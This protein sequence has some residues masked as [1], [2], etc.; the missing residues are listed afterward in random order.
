MQLRVGSLSLIAISIIHLILPTWYIT[1]YGTLGDKDESETSTGLMK[2]MQ[3]D[4][5]E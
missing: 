5:K 2:K 4:L 3:T 1:D